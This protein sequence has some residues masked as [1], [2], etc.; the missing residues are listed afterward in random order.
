MKKGF[1]SR[2]AAL[3]DLVH[4]ILAIVVGL[5]AGFLLGSVFGM[6]L[7]GYALGFVLGV[8]LVLGGFSIFD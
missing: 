2:L 7:A 3:V 8:G 4:L 6:G 1:W 5:A